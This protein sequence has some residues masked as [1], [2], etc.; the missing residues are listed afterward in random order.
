[1]ETLE[2]VTPTD[3]RLKALLLLQ[4]VLGKSSGRA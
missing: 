4:R 2:G 1:L 3:D